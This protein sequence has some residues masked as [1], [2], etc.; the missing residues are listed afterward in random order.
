MTSLGVNEEPT[1][2]LQNEV[3]RTSDPPPHQAGTGLEMADSMLRSH[4]PAV[5]ILRG[6]AVL[7]VITFHGLF[8]DAPQFPWQNP[9]A[10]KLFDATAIGWTGVN[11]FFVLSG[12]L[13]TGNLMDSVGRRNYYARFYIR[14]ALRILPVYYVLV[15][16]LAL[17]HEASW[18]YTVVCLLFLANMPKLF[19]HGSYFGLIPAWS[20]AVEEQFYLLWPA[21]YRLLRRRGI[22]I[23]CL[24]A[25]VICPLLRGASFAHL[26]RMGE[27]FSKTWMIAD[28]L[29]VGA[30]VAALA[31]TPTVTLRTVRWAGAATLVL[32]IGLLA[33]VNQRAVSIKGSTL[34]ASLGYSLIELICASTLVLGL[35]FFR[36]RALPSS[37][38]IFVFFADISYGLYL[39]HIACAE[40]YDH[41]IKSDYQMQVSALLLR[42]FIVNGVAIG[43]ATLSKRYFENP[44]MQLRK[45]L[46]SAA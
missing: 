32:S 18:N 31:R 9:L 46:P 20:L 11:L 25:M 44:I 29:A 19:L 12:F 34:G 40:A 42:F 3:S 14:R 4:M 22:I 13:I 30:L 33:I 26:L 39:L 45:H 5:D 24:S 6:V 17:L 1:G 38:A 8:F 37:F 23:L 15:L 16:I 43:L 36:K 2:L 35:I 28:N 41:F 21:I 7:M 10:Q 27:V